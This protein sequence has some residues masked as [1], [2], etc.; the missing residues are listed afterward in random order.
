MAIEHYRLS[1]S[2]NSDHALAHYRLGVTLLSHATV[3]E[4][5]P[6]LREAVRLRPESP[7]ILN[8]LAWTLATQSNER[9]R[10]PVEA[11]RLAQ[12]AVEFDDSPIPAHLDTLAAAYAAMGHFDLA[13]AT[14]EEALQLISSSDEDGRADKI[15][16]RLDLYRENQ[17]YFATRK[18]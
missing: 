15:R 17:P 13:T 5:L 14:A 4:S 11:L 7:T 9:L 12:R 10:D 8:A 1:L 16:R 6:H 2:S 18:K 3:A